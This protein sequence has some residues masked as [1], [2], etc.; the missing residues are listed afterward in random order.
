MTYT[1]FTFFT[2]ALYI[3]FLQGEFFENTGIV[4]AQVFSTSKGQKA[5]SYDQTADSV[6]LAF[7]F[8]AFFLLFL[9]FFVFI[10]FYIFY[11]GSNI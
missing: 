5:Y 7:P 3:H 10:I 9:L 2:F 8:F 1:F 6:C 11:H 4:S